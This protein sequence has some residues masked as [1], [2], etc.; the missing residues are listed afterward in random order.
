MV[1]ELKPHKESKVALD[2]EISRCVKDRLD[3]ILETGD[4]TNMSDLINYAIL[5]FIP[6]YEHSRNE[7][8]S[9]KLGELEQYL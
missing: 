9:D 4:F 1:K 2:I 8:L 5:H 7:Y 6:D 3:D